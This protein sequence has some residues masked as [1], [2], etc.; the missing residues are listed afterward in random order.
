MLQTSAGS[1]RYSL[2]LLLT[3]VQGKPATTPESCWVLSEIVEKIYC[4]K[5]HYF[6]QMFQQPSLIMYKGNDGEMAVPETQLLY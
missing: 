4:R 1:F 5:V 2:A 6:M 3:A